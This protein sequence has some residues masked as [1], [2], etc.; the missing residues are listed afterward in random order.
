MRD[1]EIARVEAAGAV[2]AQNASTSSLENAQNAFSTAPTRLNTVLPMSSD[3][4]VTY[5]SGCPNL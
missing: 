2:D 5:V 1:D 4:F 3:E